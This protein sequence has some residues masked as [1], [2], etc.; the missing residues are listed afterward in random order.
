M[1]KSRFSEEQITGIL[2]EYRAGLSATELCRKHSLSLKTFYGWKQKYGDLQAAEVRRMKDMQL[3]IG[4]L[5]KIVARQAVEL[6]A[7]QEL[8]RGK[9]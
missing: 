2:S 1:R 6:L 5:E 4:K 9:W 7:A 3:Q 8:L